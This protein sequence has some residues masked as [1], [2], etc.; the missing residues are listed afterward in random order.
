MDIQVG[1]ADVGVASGVSLF[2]EAGAEPF[3]D[4]AK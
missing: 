1:L 3:I 4:A 2:H